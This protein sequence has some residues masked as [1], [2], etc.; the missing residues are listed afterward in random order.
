MRA[1]QIT[2]APKK[3]F[4]IT[5]DRLTHFPYGASFRGNVTT[6]P[7]RSI[8]NALSRK[9]ETVRERENK[10]DKWEGGV[11]GGGSSNYKIMGGHD[12]TGTNPLFH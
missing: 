2:H 8:I 5:V 7:V 9:K 11:M 1:P 12:L 6:A 3:A 10:I 4:V